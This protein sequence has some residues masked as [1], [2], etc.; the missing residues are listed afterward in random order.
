MENYIKKY[1][2]EHRGDIV[3]MLK[4]IASIPSV[5]G[6]PTE[7]APFG[8]G[9]KRVL[10]RTKE[11]YDSEGFEVAYGEDF[12]YLKVTTDGDEKLIGI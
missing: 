1:L 12:K 4:D 8:E 9:C 6:V 5:K 2:T 7:A 3:E 11:I 10:E